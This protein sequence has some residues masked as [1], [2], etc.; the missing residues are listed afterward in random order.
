MIR[1]YSR[2]TCTVLIKYGEVFC[3]VPD[4]SNACVSIFASWLLGTFQLIVNRLEMHALTS[5][6]KAP[7]VYSLLEIEL[8]NTSFSSSLP[9][10][11]GGICSIARWNGNLYPGLNFQITRKFG[12]ETQSNKLFDWETEVSRW[13][14]VHPQYWPRLVFES[15]PEREESSMWCTRTI[16]RKK[17]KSMWTHSSI[18]RLLDNWCHEKSISTPL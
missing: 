10:H 13:W 16:S 7:N 4:C 9:K 8:T 18:K 3:H 5:H 1:K 15:R 17:K 14:R 12:I 2:R 6:C 11:E